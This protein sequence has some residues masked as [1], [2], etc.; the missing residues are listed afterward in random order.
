MT[1]YAALPSCPPFIGGVCTYF[2]FLSPSARAV[3]LRFSATRLLLFLLVAP[4]IR[5]LLRPLLCS[6][7]ASVCSAG[8]LRFGRLPLSLLG[9]SRL[10]ILFVILFSSF[11]CFFFL[12][13]F[14]YFI[15]SSGCPRCS[16]RWWLLPYPR[17]FTCWRLLTEVGLVVFFY[18]F[19]GSLCFIDCPRVQQRWGSTKMGALWIGRLPPSLL[20]SSRKERNAW[21]AI[22]KT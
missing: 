9:S 10:P 17:C 1:R 14:R 8:S 5:S 6:T 21:R 20:T 13:L 3:L 15:W 11:A 12:L 22:N 19:F 16:P 18:I 4:F 2:L 7:G